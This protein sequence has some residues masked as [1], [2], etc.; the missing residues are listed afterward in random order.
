MALSI[1]VSLVLQFPFVYSPLLCLLLSASSLELLKMT[2][3]YQRVS[4]RRRRTVCLGRMGVAWG[5]N[6]LIPSCGAGVVSY[7]LN[8]GPAHAHHGVVLSC[9]LEGGAGRGSA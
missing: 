6:A 5:A 3:Q 9:H 2:A 8:E 7:V 4:G 1:S